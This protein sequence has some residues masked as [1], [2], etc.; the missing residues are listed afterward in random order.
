MKS[1]LLTIPF[2]LLSL[3]VHFQSFLSLLR[4][5]RGILN[6]LNTG[7]SFCS[8]LLRIYAVLQTAK[9]RPA[10]TAGSCQRMAHA[11]LLRIYAVLQTA[12]RR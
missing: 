10:R 7:Q 11:I 4:I 12:K 9:R 3:T 8:I 1:F 6:I 5:K 2:F